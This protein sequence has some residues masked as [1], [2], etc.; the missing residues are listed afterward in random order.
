MVFETLATSREGAVL[1]AEIAAP[2]MNLLGPELVR[3]LAS[4]I[5][6]AEADDSIRVLVFKSADPAYLSLS[7]NPWH[8]ALVSTRHKRN[9]PR[10][11]P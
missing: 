11:Q 3:D 6:Q 10:R 5:Q 9:Q 8:N 4:L 2:P 1:F 7:R